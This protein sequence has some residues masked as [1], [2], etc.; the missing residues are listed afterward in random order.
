MLTD[1]KKQEFIKNRGNICPYCG[2]KNLDGLGLFEA[3]DN[4]ATHLI[5]CE[6]CGKQ[7]KD[8]YILSGII[9]EEN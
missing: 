8:F 6:S 3:D 9:E 7:W 2:S 4:Y 1:E 5:H